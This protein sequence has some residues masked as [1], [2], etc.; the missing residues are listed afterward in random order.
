[1]AAAEMVLD[2]SV[3]TTGIEVIELIYSKSM[4]T[5]LETAN[6]V[7]SPYQASSE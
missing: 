4:T 6:K 7:V 2:Y 3:K 5:V 1:M